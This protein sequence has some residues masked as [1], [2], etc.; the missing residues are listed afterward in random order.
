[1]NELHYEWQTSEVLRSV[2]TT[3]DLLV[4]ESLIRQAR[5]EG[6]DWQ[7]SEVEITSLLL[8]AKATRLEHVALPL[9]EEDLTEQL[10]RDLWGDDEKLVQLHPSAAEVVGAFQGKRLWHESLCEI[11][12]IAT[13]LPASGRPIVIAKN[14]ASYEFAY[15]RRLAY[16][17]DQVAL[18]LINSID[19]ISEVFSKRGFTH[20]ALMKSLATAAPNLQTNEAVSQALRNLITR[21]ISVLTGGPGTGKT[22]T[23][24]AFLAALQTEALLSNQVLKVARCAPT[25]KASV[26]LGEQIEA[27]FSELPMSDT[28]GLTFDARSGSVQRLLRMHKNSST[29]N[30]ELDVDLLI[31]DEVSMLDLGLLEQLLGSV[32]PHTHVLLVGDPNQLISVR[33]GAILR[34]IVELAAVDGPARAIVTELTVAHRFGE[35]INALAIAINAGDI[36]AVNSALRTYSGELSRVESA[37]SVSERVLDWARQLTIASRADDPTAGIESLRTLSVLCGTRM[38]H[39]S[40]AWWTKKIQ[41]SLVVEGRLAPDER[42]PTGAPIM[43][44]KNELRAGFNDTE[45]LSNGDLGLAMSNTSGEQVVFGPSGRPRVRRPSDIE[46]FELGWSLTIHK[47]QGSDYDEV[48]VSLPPTKGTFVSRELLYTAVTRAKAK[49]TIIGSLETIEAAIKI[50]ANRIGGLKLRLAQ[51]LQ[52]K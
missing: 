33:V 26:R 28:Y 37:D 12:D 22:F 34:D 8:L 27:A 18:E 4:A 10:R 40:V 23:V 30:R 11:V 39:G 31:V 52:A 21:R 46:H 43:V 25:S 2:F 19:T 3:G 14:G 6:S 36:A 5:M 17:E 51:K 7:P 48:I 29:A 15:L 49:V 32:Q 13:D 47:S 44:T 41:T 20:D 24:A 35:S 16:A 38:G 50:R 45:A 42:V 1:M 9:R